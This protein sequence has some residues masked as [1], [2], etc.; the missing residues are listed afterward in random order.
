MR[1][2]TRDREV[3]RGERV[4][5]GVWRLRLPIKLPGVP[6]VNAWA[7][8]AGDGIV[9]V[10]SGMDEP[11]SMAN[12]ERAL[13][14]TA[15]RLADVRL[16]VLTHAHPDH[17]GQA[18]PIARR[19]GCEV[20]ITPPIG[21]TPAATR[22]GWSVAWRWRARAAC[23]RTAAPLGRAPAEA[24]SGIAG[25][26]RSDRDLSPACGSTPTAARGR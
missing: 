2:P 26:L 5:R 19:L 13:E 12:L 4:L 6:H 21:C 24:R 18:M 23:P 8:Q 16:I 17:A 7:L 15:H 22:T 1:K 3:G 10:D 20:W 14:R 9:L 11:G 25:T